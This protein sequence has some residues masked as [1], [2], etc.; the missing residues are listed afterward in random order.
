MA[1]AVFSYAA[2]SAR[3]PGLAVNVPEPLADQYFAEAG[4][5][6][7]NTDCSPV[8]DVNQRLRFLN[9]IVAHIAVVEGANNG[10][11]PGP[12]GRLSSVTEGSVSLS[13]ELKGFDGDQAAF[14]S[15]TPYGVQY[16]ALTAPWR[17]ATYVPGPQPFLGVPGS[18]GLGWP[19]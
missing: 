13:T 14:F 9:L 8:G 3:Y 6:L 1:I 7:D 19:Y 17:S 2:W 18:G 16:W 15:Q 12:V 11:T 5:Y 10:G 4:D